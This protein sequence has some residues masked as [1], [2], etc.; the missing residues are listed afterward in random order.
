MNSSPTDP[1]VAATV[2]TSL[3]QRNLFGVR[4]VR[5]LVQFAGPVGR[6]DLYD[7][8]VLRIARPPR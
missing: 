3:Y 6:G 7:G 2:I 5:W 8:G 4:I 1:P